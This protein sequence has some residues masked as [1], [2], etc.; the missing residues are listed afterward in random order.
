MFNRRLFWQGL[1]RH[2]SRLWHCFTASVHWIYNLFRAHG[3]H[4]WYS[5]LGAVIAYQVGFS[6]VAVIVYSICMNLFPGYA[7]TSYETMAVYG[8]SGTSTSQ[9]SP[10]AIG[11]NPLQI[12]SRTS[13]LMPDGW[14]PRM[15]YSR[16]TM[17]SDGL[18]PSTIFRYSTDRSSGKE[19]LFKCWCGDKGSMTPCRCFPATP[20]TTT[21]DEKSAVPETRSMDP[22]TAA[23]ETLKEQRKSTTPP[24]ASCPV[25]QRPMIH[26]TTHAAL[27][28]VDKYPP[29]SGLPRTKFDSTSNQTVSLITTTSS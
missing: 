26:H 19:Q 21:P 27:E 15:G 25:C 28:M 24:S 12:D 2:L 17:A 20:T 7:S 23:A 10:F 22:F 14:M 4:S 9:R 11:S 5:I 8:T 29:R 18:D 1:E 13:S 6:L 3:P 16:T